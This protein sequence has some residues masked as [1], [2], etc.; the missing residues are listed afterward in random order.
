M[1]MHPNDWEGCVKDIYAGKNELDYND[2]ASSIKA[3][4]PVMPPEIIIPEQFYD[5]SRS[6]VSRKKIDEVEKDGKKTSIYA[7]VGYSNAE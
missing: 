4:K 5:N 2:F 6:T 7:I 3:S 1:K